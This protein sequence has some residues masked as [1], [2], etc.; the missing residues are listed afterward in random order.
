MNYDL[1]NSNNLLRSVMNMTN[2][3]EVKHWDEQASLESQ[4]I[5]NYIEELNQSVNILNEEL[6]KSKLE[7]KSKPFF[8]RL[9]S[10]D[11]QSNEIK[12]QLNQIEK[13]CPKLEDAR[14][15]LDKW[16]GMTPDDEV[17]AKQMVA[18]LKLAKKELGV[19]KKE[20]RANIKQINTEARIQNAKISNRIFFTSPKL[21][22]MQRISVRS[23]KENS[24]QPFENMVFEI[25]RQILEMDKMI[26]WIDRIR[27]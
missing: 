22:K 18:E 26:N 8:S 7:H 10:S 27:F 21:K 5:S 11:K 13:L 20:A 4:K 9:F 15:E 24:L 14:Y 23:E 17:E 16:V 1:S 19:Q 25:D 6:V 12:N 2:F 3:D